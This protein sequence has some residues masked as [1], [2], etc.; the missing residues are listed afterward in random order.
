MPR[1]YEVEVSFIVVADDEDDAVRRVRAVLD[2]V[3]YTLQSGLRGY[4]T[5]DGCATEHEDQW[6]A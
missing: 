3:E 4:F 5:Y 2:P 1:K 6:L